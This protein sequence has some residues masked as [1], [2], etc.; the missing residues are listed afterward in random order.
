[1]Q[2]NPEHNRNIRFFGRFSSMPTGNKSGNDF[3]GV[4]RIIVK[5]DV[6]AER[7]VQEYGTSMT[8]FQLVVSA[9]DPLPVRYPSSWKH[10]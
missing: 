8:H 10:S 6:V 9:K 1:M 7:N 5:R 4:S 2:G 3:G